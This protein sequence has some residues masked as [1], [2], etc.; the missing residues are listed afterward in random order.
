MKKLQQENHIECQ[1]PGERVG[2]AYGSLWD[3]LSGTL[4][5]GTKVPPYGTFVP[6]D[7]SF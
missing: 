5:Q 7:E 2:V 1:S 3:G 4:F 6:G